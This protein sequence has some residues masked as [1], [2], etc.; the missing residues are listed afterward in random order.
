MVRRKYYIE[1]VVS[2]IQWR[3][4]NQPRKQRGLTNALNIPRARATECI[5]NALGLERRKRNIFIQ[6]SDKMLETLPR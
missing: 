2:L 4:W 1:G 3:V 5:L 6:C